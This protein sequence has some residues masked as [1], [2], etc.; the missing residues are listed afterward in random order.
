MNVDVWF[1]FVMSMLVTIMNLLVFCNGY[2]FTE[3]HVDMVMNELVIH[4]I[5]L[6]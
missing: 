6:I 3:P 4:R 1:D 2:E 5:Q